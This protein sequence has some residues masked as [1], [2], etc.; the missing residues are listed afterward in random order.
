ML[1]FFGNLAS[2]SF[3][4][5]LFSHF[6]HFPLE[7]KLHEL[8]IKFFCLFFDNFFVCCINIYASKMRLKLQDRN[9]INLINKGLSFAVGKSFFEALI[10]I[11]VLDNYIL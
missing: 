11:M 6:G 5:S 4:L 3:G 9:K 7:I 2:I 1:N 10:K 8:F